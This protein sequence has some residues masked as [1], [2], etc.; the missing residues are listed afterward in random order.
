MKIIWTKIAREDLREIKIYISKDSVYY[1]NCVIEKIIFT[2]EKLSIFPQMGRR[3]REAKDES[4][5]EIIYNSYRIIYKI[6]NHSISILGIIHTRR[7]L[8][9]PELQQWEVE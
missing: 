1:A 8:S 6:D 2:A 7:D 3:V 5:R 9:N 4:L